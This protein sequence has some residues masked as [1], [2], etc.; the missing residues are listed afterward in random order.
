MIQI[1]KDLAI[2]ENELA[3][4]F[5]RASGPGGQNVNKV[6][7][8]VQLRFDVEGSASLP[9]DVRSRLKRIAHN[10]IN[11]EGVLIIEARQQRTQEQ[12]R[13][14]AVTRLVGL[15][16]LA[17][18][19]PRIRKK[20]QPTAESRRRRLEEKRR[21]GEIKRLRRPPTPPEG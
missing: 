21:R 7:S 5:I 2:D 15:L 19:K 20:T 1:T 16:R 3:F 6:S 11:N 17:A 18:R 12:N 10:R 8:A 13:Q 4:D 9:E 14:E